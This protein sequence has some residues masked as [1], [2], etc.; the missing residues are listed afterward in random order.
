LAIGF[1]LGLIGFVFL[2]EPA[3][4]VTYLLV[5]KGLTPILMFLELGLFTL[6]VIEL[7]V[8][9]PLNSLNLL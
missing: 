7:L 1:V 8:I 3:D 2:P 5:L 9:F 6:K 4:K